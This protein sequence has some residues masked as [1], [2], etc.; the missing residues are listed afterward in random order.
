MFLGAMTAALREASYAPLSVFGMS[1]ANFGKVYTG[2]PA[3]YTLACLLTELYYNAGSPPDGFGTRVVRP[4]GAV[5]LHYTAKNI[6]DGAMRRLFALFGINVELI[7][8]DECDPLLWLTLV[9]SL[10]CRVIVYCNLGGGADVRAV[11]LA[12]KKREVPVDEPALD[13]EW[14]C[15]LKDDDDDDGGASAALRGAELKLVCS[16]L[17]K[18]RGIGLAYDSPELPALRAAAFDAVLACPFIDICKDGD[19][20][21]ASCAPNLD[22]PFIADRWGSAP[23][24][25][26]A[27]ETGS[28]DLPSIDVA[29]LAAT[30]LPP[31][32]SPDDLPNNPGSALRSALRDEGGVNPP[33]DKRLV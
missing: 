29:Q 4:T 32:A 12:L 1:Q 3:H 21:I 20:F 18:K 8:G 6:H 10:A 15:S 13:V 26:E 16:A 33:S 14:W 28:A 19:A 25:V 5:P 2:A 23:T 9:W 30:S 22:I 24:S 7:H 11:D 17:E 27:I 31:Y